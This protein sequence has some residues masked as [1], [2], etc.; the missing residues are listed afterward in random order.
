MWYSQ[1]LLSLQRGI[2]GAG[3]EEGWNGSQSPPPRDLRGN[4][5]FDCALWTRVPE[6]PIYLAPQSSCEWAPS[7]PF[8]GCIRMADEGGGCFPT[9]GWIPFLQ[10]L[11][12]LQKPPWLQSCPPS[13]TRMHSITICQE[14]QGVLLPAATEG[15]ANQP[16]LQPMTH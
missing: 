3:W 6:L 2:C 7:W 4:N 12:H 1:C 15:A 8:P 13:M 5:T 11:T 10:L 14:K 16:L 9:K